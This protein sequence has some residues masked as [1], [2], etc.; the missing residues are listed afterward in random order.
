MLSALNYEVVSMIIAK[1]IGKSLQLLRNK[2]RITQKTASELSGI[3][4]DFIKKIEIGYSSPSMRNLGILLQTY[5]SSWQRFGE[6][7]DRLLE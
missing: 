7:M 2:K 6:I 4:L 5:D 1:E 3:S